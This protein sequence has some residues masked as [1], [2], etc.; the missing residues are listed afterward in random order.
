MFELIKLI[1]PNTASRVLA[2]NGPF[3]EKRGGG[4]LAEKYAMSHLL[5]VA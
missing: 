2:E 3:P 1:S 4:E 5:L